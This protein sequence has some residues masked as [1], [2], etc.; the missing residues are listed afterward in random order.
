MNIGIDVHASEADGSGN[1]TYIR[2]ILLALL[3]LDP[4]HDFFLYAT[5]RNH[6]FYGDIPNRPN[7]HLRELPV[8]RPFLRIPFFLARAT[9]RDKLDILHVQY[10]APPFHRGKLVATIHDLAF[11]HVPETFSKFFV[12]RSKVFIRRTARR[13]ARVITGSCFSRDDIVATYGLDPRK[14]EVVPYGVSPEFAKN[15]PARDE[16]VLSAHGIRRPYVLF[17]GR[18][19]SRK[20]LISLARAFE[21]MKA[22]TRL[23]HRL[24]IV[25]KEDFETAKTLASLDDIRRDVVLTG[26]VPDADLPS[27]YRQADVFIYP[28]LFEGGGL[29]VLE[30]MAAGVPVVTSNVSSL[31]EIIGDAGLVVDPLDLDEMGRALI[32]T[33]TDPG[34]REECRNKGRSR[35]ELFSWDAAA[36]KTLQIY[37]DAAGLLF[38]E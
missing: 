31:P 29:P 34:F 36:R 13:A 20:N 28:S 27:L 3:A 17:V 30:A 22:A 11:L 23:P 8:R 24:V 18:L 16:A 9:V 2:R 32:R 37:E 1:C 6:P 19:N 7:I 35:A 12:W 15:D 38:R 25:G 33:A 21:R 26:Y 5:D 4:P 14:I 10:I